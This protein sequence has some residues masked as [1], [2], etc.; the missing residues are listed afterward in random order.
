MRLLI[1]EKIDCDNKRSFDWSFTQT[2]KAENKHL[3]TSLELKS[4][5][6]PIRPR[7]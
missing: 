7:S 4:G 6:D 3:N 1:E 5:F 2:E